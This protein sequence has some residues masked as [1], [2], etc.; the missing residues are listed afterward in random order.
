[1]GEA[2]AGNGH[3][4]APPRA[5]VLTREEGTPLVAR[6]AQL[7]FKAIGAETGGAFSLMDR[8][9]PA[10]GHRRPVP[11][12]CGARAVGVSPEFVCV[13]RAGATRISGMTF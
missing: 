1:M 4:G 3:D 8:V 11:R 7:L 6:G 13:T 5:M 2:D 9:L 10:G 12:G